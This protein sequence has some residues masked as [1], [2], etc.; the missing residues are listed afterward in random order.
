M[1][2]TKLSAEQV[3]L[4]DISE[5]IRLQA[6]DIVKIERHHCYSY[7][8]WSNNPIILLQILFVTAG[9]LRTK[10]NRKLNKKLMI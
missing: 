4:R 8:F 2:K 1:E 10:E 6:N 5:Y 7:G 3:A 9:K